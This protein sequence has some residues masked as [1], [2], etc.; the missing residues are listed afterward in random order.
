MTLGEV[1]SIIDIAKPDTQ[2]IKKYSLKENVT[3]ESNGC[4]MKITPLAIWAHRLQ[5]E[6][7]D[8]AV[9]A[10]VSLTH[11][12]ERVQ[13]ACV[14]YCLCIKNLIKNKGD[15]KGAIEAIKY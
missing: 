3:S 7:L 8:K 12:N 14:C 6:D 5:D 11:P 1:F 10:E 2:K 4:L 15:R 13:E 9:R